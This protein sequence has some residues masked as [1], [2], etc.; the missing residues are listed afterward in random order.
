MDGDLTNK[1][2]QVTSGAFHV[3]SVFFAKLVQQVF[4]DWQQQSGLK[5]AEISR[6]VSLSLGE[7]L[8][9]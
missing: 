1:L 8:V 4:N 7:N 9:Y 2:G 5:M 6:I 3:G